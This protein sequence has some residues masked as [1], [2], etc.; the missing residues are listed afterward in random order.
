MPLL[1]AVGF[2]AAVLRGC[3]DCHVWRELCIIQIGVG[4]FADTDLYLR[5]PSR[6]SHIPDTDMHITPFPAYYD[7]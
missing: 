2:S 6:Y 3:H 4:K 5:K 1:A 7:I